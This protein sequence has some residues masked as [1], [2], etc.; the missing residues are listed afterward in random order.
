M[1]QRNPRNPRNPRNLAS[2]ALL[3]ALAGALAACGPAPAEGPPPQL[4]GAS[5]TPPAPPAPSPSS[6][7][8]ATPPAP[9]ARPDV[10]SGADAARDAELA[11]HAASLVDAFIN[12]GA[13][14]SPDGKTLL[15]GSNRSGHDQLYVADA[16]RPD[17]P[18]RLLVSTAE[19]I[20]AGEI[21]PDGKAV[22]FLSD[23][24]ADEN[25]SIFRVDLDGK[26]LAELTPG[27]RLQRTTPILPDGA[28]GTMVYSARAHADVS[29][30]VVVQASVAGSTPQVV[31][32]AP[33]PAFITDARRDG[34][35]ALLIQLASMSEMTLFV[36][37]LAAGTA[38][39]IYPA[40]GKATFSDARFSADGK[41]VFLSTDAGGEAGLVLALDAATGKELARYIEERPKTARTADLE[42]SK[43]G[44]LVAVRVDAG[45]RSEI[46]LLDAR[47][48]KPTKPV[49]L[50]LGG[51]SLGAFSKD[52]K[53][54]AVTWS[55]PSAPTDIF[56]IDTATGKVSP[57]R[58][59]DRKT[60]G[61]LPPV[62]TSI[63]EVPSFDGT[64][65]PVNLYLPPAAARKQPMPVLVM[66]HGGP[67]SSSPIRW[68][69]SHRFFGSL[70]YAI[71]EP[72]IRGS[73]GFGRAYEEADNGPKRLDA[74]KDLEAVA[75][76]TATQPWAD[77][78][79][80]VVYGG[81]YGG[82]MVL[83]AV[84][85][86]PELW[87]AGI[88][89]VGISSVRS[90]LQTTTGYIREAFK[91]EF[92]DV[93]RDARFLDSI[94]PLSDAPKIVD[95][96]FVYAGAN[97]PRVPLAESD[98]IVVALR[99]KGVPVEY[100]VKND[101]G[102]SLDLRENQVEFYARVARFLEKHLQLPKPQ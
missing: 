3:L 42:V 8:P 61:A 79:R 24:G 35:R 73:T 66:V 84:T 17:A 96:L 75:R 85:R 40:S 2:L 58:K 91:I 18:A 20:S 87:R 99:Q 34:Q 57:L 37:D 26:N 72:N 38:K 21:T 28:P 14:F 30:R 69:A 43:A 33:K 47:T 88:D 74:L 53:R 102:H 16:A 92:G 1:H 25:L 97:D 10:P 31:Y 27:E 32:T 83:M 90:F 51:G 46:R 55:T 80:L 5:P 6:G 19:R 9:S 82:Y 62:E 89:L 15:F 93:D 36:V 77:K 94:S 78:D 13:S 22:I 65:V 12:S 70:G 64:K 56:A 54:L 44:D 59:E 76:W 41:R 86:Q 71:V 60:L 23:K 29:T 101:E 45:N 63:V 48:L 11:K 4:P 7:S 68:S 50:P 100:M 67:A 49:T 52:G 39:P 81:S 98:Q 95:P